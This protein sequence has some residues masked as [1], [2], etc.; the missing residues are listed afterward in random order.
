MTDSQFDNLKAV[1]AI[2]LTILKRKKPSQGKARQG[3]AVGSQSA[4]Q[5]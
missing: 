1:I 3:E 4:T 2:K 5:F